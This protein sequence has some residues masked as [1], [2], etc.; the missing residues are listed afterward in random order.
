MMAASTLA[1]LPLVI[2]FFFTQRYFL[3][4]ITVTGM[5]G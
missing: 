1:T 4:G 5:K 3:Q 2:V